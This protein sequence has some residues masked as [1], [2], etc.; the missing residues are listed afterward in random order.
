[1]GGYS[2]KS[3]GNHVDMD[4]DNPIYPYCPSCYNTNKKINNY[5][6][7]IT[8]GICTCGIDGDKKDA[9][10]CGCCDKAG[11]RKDDSCSI[12][13]ENK[14]FIIISLGKRKWKNFTKILIKN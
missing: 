5:C 1:M 4:K 11:E 10:N 6:E 2:C 8:C 12:F 13:W 9:V 3:C 7:I 14:Y